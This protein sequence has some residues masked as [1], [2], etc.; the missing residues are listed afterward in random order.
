MLVLLSCSQM[1]Q[2]IFNK[3]RTLR[4]SNSALSQ[5]IFRSHIVCIAC[6]RGGVICFLTFYFWNL[7]VQNFCVRFQDSVK[8]ALHEVS[9]WSNPI[10]VIRKMISRC[11]QRIRLCCR[12]LLLLST[13]CLTWELNIITGLLD[14]MFCHGTSKLTLHIIQWSCFALIVRKSTLFHV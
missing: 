11:F 13:F 12:M 9:N 3:C 6:F 10:E 4:R 5:S 2:K 7:G 8:N 14:K 1:T